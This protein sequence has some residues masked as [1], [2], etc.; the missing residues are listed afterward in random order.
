MKILTFESAAYLVEKTKD[1][2][3]A[4]VGGH[5]HSAD[6]IESGTLSIACG[7]TG[8]KSAEEA[9]AALG[10]YSAA[11]VDAMLGDVSAVLESLTGVSP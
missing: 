4:Q 9:R 8:A 7:G 1:Y 6:E 5:G 10:V 2:C 11:E 3:L